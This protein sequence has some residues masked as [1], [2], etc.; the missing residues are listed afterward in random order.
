MGIFDK[1][2]GYIDQTKRNGELAREREFNQIYDN[3]ELFQEGPFEIDYIGAMLMTGDKRPLVS[4][5]MEW[6]NTSKEPCK[7]SE[8]LLSIS[9]VQAGE[10]LK[11]TGFIFDEEGLVFETPL[12]AGTRDGDALINFE[13]V[14]LSDSVE[15]VICFADGKKQFTVIFPEHLKSDLLV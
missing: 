1:L 7:L 2:K 11:A 6:L 10:E 15:V 5:E 3:S 9:A 14:N 4:I 13:L 8:Y 12:D